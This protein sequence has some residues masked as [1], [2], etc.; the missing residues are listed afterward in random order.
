M[1]KDTTT[2]PAR[3]A[4]TTVKPIAVGSLGAAAI[5]AALAITGL[6]PDEGKWNVAK[7]DF[8]Q[9]VV[10]ECYGHTGPD[11]KLGQRR[12]DAQCEAEL[13]VDVDRE[14]KGV[15]ACVPNVTARPATWAAYTRMAHNTGVSA[16]CRSS[17]AR[18]SN[19]GQ[20]RA[21]CDAM[22]LWDKAVVRGVKVAVPGLT[23]RR[24]R[25]R[26]QCLAGIAADR[27]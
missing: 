6:K 8:A 27:A 17:T 1:P 5:A 26:A 24:Q 23:A 22:L 13:S 14:M 15:A 12:T 16:F 19:A 3:R 4:T 25:E 20:W 2:S 18:L 11:V 10:T 7:R 9:G 21:G